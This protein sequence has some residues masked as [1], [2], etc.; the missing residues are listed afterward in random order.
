MAFT[1]LLQN[2]QHQLYRTQVYII[3]EYDK[4]IADHYQYRGLH[5]FLRQDLI[6]SGCNLLLVTKHLKVIVRKAQDPIEFEG[7]VEEIRGLFGEEIKSLLGLLPSTES[8]QESKPT[9]ETSG[10]KSTTRELMGA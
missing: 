6:L 5:I 9:R 4:L 2:T 8:P 1:G 3:H 7:S 10:Y